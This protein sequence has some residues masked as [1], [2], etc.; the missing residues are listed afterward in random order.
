[1]NDCNAAVVVFFIDG[2]VLVIKRV[3]NPHDPWSGQ[4]ALP[5]G[6][7]EDNE[8]CEETAKRE[9]FEE[10]GIRPNNLQFI[11]IYSP[12]NFPSLKVY[13][14][15]SCLKERID[16]KIDPKE[17][18]KAFWIRLE[19]LR[20]EGN[21]FYYGQYRIWGMTYRILRDFIN[22]KIYLECQSDND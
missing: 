21:A 1:M 12:N 4:M 15:L 22:K 11:G 17:V 9:A 14:Y 5:G 7:R 13:A 19:E 16:P 18:D 6:K 10:V 20:N 2:S 8:S 3:E